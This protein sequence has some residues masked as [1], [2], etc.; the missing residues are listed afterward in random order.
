LPRL[1]GRL[2]APHPRWGVSR[3]WLTPRSAARQSAERGAPS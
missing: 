3:L 1:L 2:R